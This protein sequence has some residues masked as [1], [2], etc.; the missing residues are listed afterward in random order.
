MRKHTIIFS[1]TRGLDSR[2]NCH[3][4]TAKISAE[5]KDNP[6]PAVV[7]SRS[8]NNL[9]ST[10]Q[11]T[12]GYSL[13]ITYIKRSSRSKHDGTSTYYHHLSSIHSFLSSYIYFKFSTGNDQINFIT[14]FTYGPIQE[15]TRA[16]KKL[17]AQYIINNNKQA[18]DHTQN[19]RTSLGKHFPKNQALQLSSKTQ[20]EKRLQVERQKHRRAPYSPR[21][22]LFPCIGQHSPPDY[23]P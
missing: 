18:S 20:Q 6:Y 16:S 23:S 8:I 13:A 17:L 5:S 19:K 11:V 7:H 15:M 2:R 12:T 21:H 3:V 10:R 4:A 9:E 22:Q 14:V 1:A